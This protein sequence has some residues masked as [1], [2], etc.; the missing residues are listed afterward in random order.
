MRYQTAGA[1]LGACL[2]AIVVASMPQRALAVCSGPVSRPIELGVSGGNIHSFN[3][4]KTLCFSGTLG[5]MVQDGSGTQFILS[6]NHVLDDSNK[7]KRGDPI[8]QPG[9]ADV[10]CVQDPTTAVANLS[11][12]VKISF[13]GGNNIVD[14][15]IAEVIPADVSS[16]I[17]NIGP[18]SSTTVAPSPGLPVQ[19]QGTATCLTTATISAVDAHGKIRYGKGKVAN[20]V[21]QIVIN[22]PLPP[23]N[24]G[25]P[26]DSGS[27]IVT[28]DSCPQAVGLLFAG[29]GDQKQ[30]IANPISNV[31]SKLHVSM[32]GGCT[33]A[34]T[35]PSAAAEQAGNATLSKELVDSA[36]AVRD[37]HDD[38]LM[39]IPGAVGTAIGVSDKPG[40]P[41]IEVYIDKM[42]PEAQASAPKEVEG[43]PVK[44]IENGGFVAY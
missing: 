14:A 8:V 43:L 7:G 44:L 39:K 11:R 42:T 17:M 41:A 28:Q 27:L 36:T 31:L 29:S 38:E 30:T 5:S 26:G 16:D 40:Q 32:T 35:A 21:H 10:A 19:K 25:G 24:F 20:F 6:N 9:L 34:V 12:A 3:K 13:G 23:N 22:G 33:A 1:V 15:A 2:L 18:I 4:K 37:R